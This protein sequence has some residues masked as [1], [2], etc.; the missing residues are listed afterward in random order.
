MIWIGF[1]LLIRMRK[2]FIAPACEVTQLRKVQLGTYALL[3]V[4][5][6]RRA[7]SLVR[8]GSCRRLDL[9]SSSTHLG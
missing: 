8:T 1:N 7:G 6:C 2:Q 5:H 9:V 3:G 4:N